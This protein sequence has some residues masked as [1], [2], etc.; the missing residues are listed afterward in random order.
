VEICVGATRF[1]QIAVRTAFD[2]TAVVK[3]EDGVGGLCC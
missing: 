1:H 2:E 3:D